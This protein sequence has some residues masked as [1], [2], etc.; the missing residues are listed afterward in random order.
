LTPRIRRAPRVLHDGPPAASVDL[1]VIRV[2][3]GSGRTKREG[4]LNVDLRG[5]DLLADGYRLPFRNGSVDEVF[6]SHF[7]E[8]LLDLDRGMREIHR[9]LRPGGRLV[10]IV[11]HG[12]RALYFPFHFH[13]FD[14]T[15]FT[16][17]SSDGPG[18][19]GGSL[20]RLVDQRV[21]CYYPPHPSLLW[22]LPRKAPWLWKMVSRPRID[23]MRRYALPLGPPFEF[24]AI[25][26]KPGVS[27]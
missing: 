24:M 8:H 12:L 11:P 17:F 3:L 20:F 21:T 10:A 5:G 9:I 15:T 16:H 22:H 26:E 6:T 2:N 23:G 4:Y 13:A 14:F 19:Q 18:L 27:P 7:L 25:L 1:K